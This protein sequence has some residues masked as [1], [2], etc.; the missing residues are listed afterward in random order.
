MER[1]RLTSME[2]G[3][4][5]LKKET[6]EEPKDTEVTVA[7]KASV[8]SPG[9]ERAFI[10]SLENTDRNY[11]RI[12]GY[13]AAGVVVKTGKMVTDFKVGDRVAGIMPHASLHN[14]ES[15][16]LVHIPDGVSFEQAS[17]VRIGVISM[18]AVRKAR[19]ELGE[20]AM[21]LG[22]GLIGQMAVQLVKVNGASPVIGLD[23]V[24][25][26]RALAKE[27]GCTY[28]CD[29]RGEDIEETLKEIGNGRLPQVVVES[30]GFPKPIEQAIRLTEKYGRVIILG[31]TRGSTEINFYRDVHKK[32]IQIIGAHISCNPTDSS[33]PG[34]WTF[35]D[36]ADCFMRLL[37]EGRVCVDRLI[38]QRADYH[39]YNEIYA[40]VLQSK[41]DYIT[42][43][44]TWEEEQ[45]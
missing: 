30:T 7:I 44:I 22:P 8:V 31:S 32:G 23:I 15:R 9:T 11:P 40:N 36:N 18:Q 24:E 26:K 38:S 43:V 16:N 1:V 29:S 12:L 21:V 2:D 10:L 4:V 3:I 27:L 20:G 42:S 35:R 45:A 39:D 34:Y 13:S 41:E 6:I 37:S 19:L 28:V 33:Y 25:S 5:F 17:F 14:A